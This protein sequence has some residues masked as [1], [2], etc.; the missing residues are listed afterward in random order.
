MNVE[1]NPSV[2]FHSIV[3]VCCMVSV[4]VVVFAKYLPLYQSHRARPYDINNGSVSFEYS[5][6]LRSTRPVNI[7][8]RLCPRVKAFDGPDIGTNASYASPSVKSPIVFLVINLAD[9]YAIFV[10]IIRLCGLYRLPETILPCERTTGK[11]RETDRRTAA[12]C[13]IFV[14]QNTDDDDESLNFSFQISPEPETPNS[15]GYTTDS[16]TRD[17]NGYWNSTNVC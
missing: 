2:R 11:S 8:K 9:I 10:L 6:R 13:D 7:S 17:W 15:V 16:W 14:S 3:I 4:V 12:N 5:V 1:P